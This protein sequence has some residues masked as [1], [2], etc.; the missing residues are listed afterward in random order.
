MT[1]QEMTFSTQKELFNSTNKAPVIIPRAKHPISRRNIDKEAIYILYKLKDSGY[2]SYL[3]GGS[4]RDLIIGKNPK[5]FDVGTD[6]QPEEIHKLFKHSKIIGKRFQLVHVFFKGG[7]YIEVST[8]RKSRSSLDENVEEENGD[9]FGTPEE[10]AF[11]RDLTI[12]ALFYNIDDYSVID[13]VKGMD[14]LHAGI[15]RIIGDPE[16]RILRDP[17]RMMRAIRHAARANFSIESQSWGAIIKHADKIRCCSI[18]RVRDEF[19][20]DLTSGSASKWL[21]L[22]LKSGIF[23]NI[24]PFYKDILCSEAGGAE[25]IKKLLFACFSQIDKIKWKYAL[26]MPYMLALLMYPAICSMPEWNELAREK[27]KFLYHEVRQL[28]KDILLPYDFKKE[29]IDKA[30][31]ILSGYW[32]INAC[33]KGNYWP[34]KVYTKDTFTKSLEIYNLT[35]KES[36]LKTVEG[37]PRNNPK[38]NKFYNEKTIN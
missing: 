38:K 21:D 29:I 2:K 3:V 4:V 27:P 24:L 32:A 33:V 10:D 1:L 5:D 30:T 19:I 22:S 15:I 6:A 14:D 23:Y 17:V 9:I 37:F 12:N 25:F 13:Y 11:R 35:M 18:P 16:T 34:K 31:I 26:D 7:K 28:N 8:F 20:K 36:G